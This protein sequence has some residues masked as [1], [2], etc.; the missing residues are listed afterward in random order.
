M[1]AGEVTQ[2]AKCLLC[3]HEDINSVLQK[4]YKTK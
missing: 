2:L 1:L 3:K 4:P